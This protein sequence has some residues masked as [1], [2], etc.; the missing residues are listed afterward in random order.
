MQG[1]DI[2]EFGSGNLGATNAFRV[3]GKRA[4]IAVLCLDMLKGLAPVALLPGLLHLRNTTAADELWIGAA[5]IL[6]HV[7]SCFVNFRGGKGVATSVGVFLAIA[8]KAMVGIIVIGVLIIWLSGYVSAGAVA[9]ALLLPIF[10][11]FS[12]ADNIVLFVGEVIA[13][14]VILRHRANLLRL[15]AGTESKIFGNHP[16]N[17]QR[18][19]QTTSS[20]RPPTK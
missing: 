12:G 17:D 11:Y 3:L 7:F 1:K 19:I 2:R 15:L 14:V 5:A 13:L 9:G 4:G 20:T 16:L 18:P 6:G 10:L 8:P